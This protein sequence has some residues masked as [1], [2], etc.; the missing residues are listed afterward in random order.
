MIVRRKVEKPMLGPE[1]IRAKTMTR[2]SFRHITH[3][4]YIIKYAPFH[5]SHV[6]VHVK[7]HVVKNAEL[8]REHPRLMTRVTPLLT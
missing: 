7:E 4:K 3:L 6:L 2:T 5:A 1:I 8:T